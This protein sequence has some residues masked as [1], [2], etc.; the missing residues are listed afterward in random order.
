MPSKYNIITSG[1]CLSI[2]IANE[3]TKLN[4][5]FRSSSVQHNRIDQLN[6]LIQGRINPLL[7]QQNE[8]ILKEKYKYTN[9]LDNQTYDSGFGKSLPKKTDKLEHFLRVVNSGRVDIF[10]L[11]TFP[12][13]YFKTFFSKERNSQLFLN[14]AY[15]ESIPSH[16]IMEDNLL[17]IE[18]IHTEYKNTIELVSSENNKAKF[19]ITNFPAN[20][21]NKDSVISRSKEIEKITNLISSELPNV[22][23]IPIIDVS[24]LD[25]KKENDIHHFND[26]KFREYAEIIAKKLEI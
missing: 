20:L 25:L 1:S 19:F 17:P 11:D 12:E 6:A 10:I 5:S 16:Y 4:N 22:Y 7:K 2:G 9:L 23:T 15:F 18:E 8:I 13:L 3:L 24:I 14:N 21:N 26:N